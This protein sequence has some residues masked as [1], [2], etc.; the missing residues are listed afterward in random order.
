MTTYI[1]TR[2]YYY[3]KCF[4]V[5]KTYY[6]RTSSR[7]EPGDVIVDVE[8]NLAGYKIIPQESEQDAFYS[9]DW[10]RGYEG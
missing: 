3:E 8:R 1:L 2:A 5:S 7:I 4:G 10:D 6:I 9:V